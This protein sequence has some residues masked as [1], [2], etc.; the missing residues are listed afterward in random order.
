MR[1]NIDQD[2]FDC[3]LPHSATAIAASSPRVWHHVNTS[4]Q[5]SVSDEVNLAPARMSAVQHLAFRVERKAAS[6]GLWLI[7]HSWNGS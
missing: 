2:P 7:F 3:S 6:E 1:A 4:T 5:V